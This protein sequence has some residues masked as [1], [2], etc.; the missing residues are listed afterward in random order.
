MLKEPF[1]IN[2]LKYGILKCNQKAWFGDVIESV[3]M[4]PVSD[5]APQSNSYCL[6]IDLFRKPT[7]G[8]VRKRG[9]VL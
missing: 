5:A 7:T 9:T 3:L 4:D 8:S 1:R 2:G 6:E